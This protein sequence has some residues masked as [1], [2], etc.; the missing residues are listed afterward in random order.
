MANFSTA[1]VTFGGARAILSGSFT[2]S[3]G[4]SPSRCTLYMA[5]QPTP[6][7]VV[8]T[9][10]FTDDNGAILF[11]DCRAQTLNVEINGTTVWAVT[12]MDTRW[13]WCFGEISGEYNI[14]DANG[15]LVPD[16]IRSVR[17]LAKLLFDALG[18][19]RVD[20]DL[21]PDNAFPEKRWEIARPDQELAK[22]CD[23]IGYRVVLGPTNTVKLWPQWVGAPLPNNAQ[24]LDVQQLFELPDAPDVLIFRPGRTQL[25]KALWLMPVAA[26]LDGTIKHINSVS[27]APTP[28]PAFP[29]L[30]ASPWGTFDEPFANAVFPPETVEGRKQRKKAER[31]LANKWVF[32]AYRI[33]ASLPEYPLTFAGEEIKEIERIL[34]LNAFQLVKKTGNALEV[35]LADNPWRKVDDRQGPPPIVFGRWSREN[36]AF[37]STN[38]DMVRTGLTEAQKLVEQDSIAARPGPTGN[39]NS[40]WWEQYQDSFSL[41]AERGIVFF[42]KP[43]Y[44]VQHTD[45]GTGTRQ[46]IKFPATLYLVTSFGVRDAIT[47][48][49]RHEEVPRDLGGKK[50]GTRPQHIY[51]SDIE[52]REWVDLNV[53]GAPV[54]NNRPE[55]ERVAK[56]HLDATQKRL[57]VNTPASA[58]YAGFQRLAPDGAIQQVSWFIDNSGHSKTRASRNRDEPDLAETYDQKRLNEQLA[59]LI[60][61]GQAELAKEKEKFGG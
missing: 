39:L 16:S 4:V 59:G 26:E 25:Q 5:P 50:Y 18:V 19:G 24:V 36:S 14:R 51:V 61:K 56:Y 11:P 53:A 22:L 20:L 48:A 52:Y 33:V 17:Q 34:P 47:R 6:L 23:E 7:R 2:L 10:V 43:V 58:T 1:Y 49:W 45:I 42:S 30:A 40:N 57:Q 37:H 41:D 31:D 3:H 29:A 55:V 54:R 21:V 12:V 13:R 32:R 8:D 38:L 9:L 60:G 15:I 35:A 44:E 46:P 27:Y 28:D